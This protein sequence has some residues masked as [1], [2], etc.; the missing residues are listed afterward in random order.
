MAYVSDANYASSIFVYYM[1]ELFVEFSLNR[2]VFSV[3]FIYVNKKGREKTCF[4]LSCLLTTFLAVMVNGLMI[5]IFL[6]FYFLPIKYILNNAP[7]QFVLIYQSGVLL[8]SGYI[9]YRAVF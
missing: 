4:V 6:Y 9:T 7:S 3:Y 1:V 5:T 8:V 2:Y